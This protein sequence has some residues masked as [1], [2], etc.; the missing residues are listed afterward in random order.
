MWAERFDQNFT[1]IFDV[2]D[3]I[4]ERIAANFVGDLSPRDRLALRRRETRNPEAYD[5]YLRA[6]D[7]WALRT[8]E[9][10]RTA[11]RMY[12]NAIAIDPAFALAYAGL[13]DSYNLTASGMSPRIRAPLARAAALR[14]LA[15]D[16]ESAEAHTAMAFLDYKFDWKW[17]DADREFRRAIELNPKYA[18]AHHWYGE[19]LKLRMRTDESARELRSAID[20]DPLSIP[21][22]YD[23]IESLL[24]ARRIA[25]PPTSLDQMPAVH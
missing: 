1:N 21:I 25:D 10:I 6:R 4:A 20:V 7:Q 9:S 22:R 12:Q 13:A 2:E 23:Y 16:P 3:A 11:I 15:L 5:L 14:A 19:C 8:P 24:A 18:L 17:D